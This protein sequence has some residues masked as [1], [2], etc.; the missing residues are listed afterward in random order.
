MAPART[1]PAGEL[2]RLP[3]VLVPRRDLR[4]GRADRERPGHVRVARALEV[5]REQV[6]DEVVVVRDTARTGVVAVRRLGA[7]ARRSG[8]RRGSRA[9][10]NTSIAVARSSSHV[11]GSPSTTRP[12]SPGSD[13]ASSVGDRGHAGLRR[14]R[15]SPD[16]LELRLGLPSPTVVEEALVWHELD[17]RSAERVRVPERERAGDARAPD[18]ERLDHP[19]DERRPDVVDVDARHGSARRRGTSRTG[20]SRS[21]GRRLRCGRPRRSTRSRRGGRPISA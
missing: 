18:P 10:A 1:E 5:V 3:R 15:R 12:P 8:R 16:P 11:S 17:A 19:H 6:A 4:V 21:R 14:A 13:R 9:S 2:E 7:A 20:R